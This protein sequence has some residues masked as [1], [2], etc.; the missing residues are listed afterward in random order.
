MNVSSLRAELDELERAGYGDCRVTVYPALSEDEAL[1]KYVLDFT[2]EEFGVVEVDL[3]GWPKEGFISLVF[4]MLD[5][6]D[7]AAVEQSAPADAQGVPP[8]SAVEPK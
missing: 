2:G 8:L 6:D 7:A 3:P 4:D 1:G 5:V